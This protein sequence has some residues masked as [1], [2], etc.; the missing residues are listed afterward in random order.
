MNVNIKYRNE[1]LVYKNKNKIIFKNIY[2]KQLWNNGNKNIPLS[3]PGSSLEHTKEYSNL[4]TKFI[5]EN[6]CK[7]VLDLGCG[8]LTWIHKTQFFNDSSIKYI[9]VDVVES[10]I[11]EHLTNFPEKQFLCKDITIFY[12]IDNVDIIIIRDV[13]FHLTNTEIL[14]IFNNIKN[15]FKFIIITSCRNSV[16]TDNFNKWHFSE[17]NIHIEPFNKSQNFFIKINEP[18]FKRNALIYTHTSFYDH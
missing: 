9:G 5:Y 1:I 11:S 3:G 2:E 7:S 17:K 4:L 10:L 15:K 18:F 8:D 6:K 13:I 14:S 12:D 16:N